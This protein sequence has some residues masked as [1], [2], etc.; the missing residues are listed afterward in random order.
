MVYEMIETEKA[1]YPVR[2]MCR[3]LEVWPSGFYA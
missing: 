3:I 2:M 1:N